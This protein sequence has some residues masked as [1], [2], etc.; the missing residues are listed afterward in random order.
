MAKKFKIL[1]ID[2]GGLRGIVPLLILK[3]IE[4]LEKKKIHQLFDLIVGTSTGGI[5]ACGLTTTKDGINPILSI[6]DMIDLYT[7][8]GHIIFPQDKS[9]LNKIKNKIN[10]L[11]NPQYSP[12]GLD[13]LL[14]EYFGD[15]T[16]N[17]TLKPIIVTSYDI[18]QNEVLMFKSRKSNELFLNP[19]IKDVCRATSAAPTYLP[20]HTMSYGDV[21]RICIDGG[22]YINNP[23]MAAISDVIK[24]KYGNNEL[25]LE[26]IHCLSLGT[27]TYTKNL[28]IKDTKN[29]GIIEW[30]KPIT[31]VMM[32]ASSKSVVY[33]CNQLLTNF[34]RLDID[35]DDK[36]RSDMADSRPE[37]TKYITEIVNNK[38]LNSKEELKNIKNFFKISKTK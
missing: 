16:L 29:W 14:T 12:D 18:K 34:L 7:T 3:K 33:E 17:Q 35:I 28:G 26:D 31:S 23:A 38:I 22:I 6:D 20:S 9:V 30:L 4:E 1:S 24:H 11:F 19:K 36:N 37:T 25:K 15:F 5:I 13:K 32:Q 10:S 2:G 21:D 8:K 27:G